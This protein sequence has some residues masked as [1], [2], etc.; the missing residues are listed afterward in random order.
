MLLVPVVSVFYIEEG[1]LPRPI[2]CVA[3]SGALGATTFP[4]LAS[5]WRRERGEAVCEQRVVGCLSPGGEVLSHVPGPA[6]STPDFQEI[7]GELRLENSG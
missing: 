7:P 6:G 5:K 3:L 1:R 2:S 4:L